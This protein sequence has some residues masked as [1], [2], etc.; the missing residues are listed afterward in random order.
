MKPS[1]TKPYYYIINR[2]TDSDIP[3]NPEMDDE[4][5]TGSYNPEFIG[6]NDY[7]FYAL[8]GSD[9][10]RVVNQSTVKIEIHSGQSS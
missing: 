7:R 8:K 5:K 9:K 3:T 2:N 1:H 6:L 4:I 10:A